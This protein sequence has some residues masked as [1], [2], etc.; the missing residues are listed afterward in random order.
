MK[1][2]P[3]Q[4][5]HYGADVWVS[6]TVEKLRREECLCL[7]CGRVGSCVAALDLYAICKSN[8]LALAVTRCPKWKEKK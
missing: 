5:E 1:T 7:N 8:N 3:A 2:K 4:E 6:P